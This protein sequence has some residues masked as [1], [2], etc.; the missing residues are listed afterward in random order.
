MWSCS[1]ML[2]HSRPMFPSIIQAG[3]WQGTLDE[4]GQ[5][6]LLAKAQTWSD[7]S[8]QTGITAC[9]LLDNTPYSAASCALPPGERA[10][11]SDACAYNVITLYS[12]SWKAVRTIS[13]MFC[14]YKTG[15]DVTSMQLQGK[16]SSAIFTCTGVPEGKPSAIARE[17]CHCQ[18]LSQSKAA[19]Q[20]PRLAQHLTPQPLRLH[21][22]LVLL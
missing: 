2:A 3:E 21:A 16:L 17:A 8:L 11:R 14:V 10:I 15:S 4:G 22:E 5:T 18:A 9:T 1:A 20:Q 12:R 7:Q 13:C 6:H 19:P